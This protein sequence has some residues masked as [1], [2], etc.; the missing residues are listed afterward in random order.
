[1]L[2]HK[3]TEDKKVMLD[4]KVKGDAGSQ[5]NRGQKGDVTYIRSTKVILL[6]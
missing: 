3:V 5:G 4:H 6:L 1:M 2:D